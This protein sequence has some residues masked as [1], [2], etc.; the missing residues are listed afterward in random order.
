MTVE[1]T[2]PL[3]VQMA[4]WSCWFTADGIDAHS[5]FNPLWEPARLSHLERAGLAAMLRVVADMLD[6]YQPRIH[7]PDPA[8]ED[9]F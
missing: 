2:S 8:D 5:I 6:T 7:L 3:T 9:T 1:E 4:P